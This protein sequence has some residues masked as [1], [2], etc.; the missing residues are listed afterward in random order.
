MRKKYKKAQASKDAMKYPIV[1]IVKGKCLYLYLKN[2][3]NINKIKELAI[4]GLHFKQFS[5]K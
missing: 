1:L 3:M 4:N 5:L 2:T